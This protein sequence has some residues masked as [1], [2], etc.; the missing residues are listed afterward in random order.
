MQ[1][2]RC[3]SRGGN[4]AR[5]QHRP[6]GEPPSTGRA[7]PWLPGAAQQD[8]QL[9][10]CGLA[11]THELEKQCAIRRGK[12]VGASPAEVIGAARWE[13]DVGIGSNREWGAHLPPAPPAVPAC[14]S[15]CGVPAPVLAPSDPPKVS[16]PS[17]ASSRPLS[18]TT[19]NGPA[20]VGLS[21]VDCCA[22]W[23]RSRSSPESAAAA[24]P[25]QR[26]QGARAHG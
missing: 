10:F 7:P 22:Q 23:T 1:Q 8:Q 11:L 4:G 5:R 26:R 16:S 12:G 2:G 19:S 14:R 3:C 24:T 20:Y 13:D 18:V 21:G 9:P 15:P 25:R 17:Q 6:P